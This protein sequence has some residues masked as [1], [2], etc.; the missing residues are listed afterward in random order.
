MPS[1]RFVDRDQSDLGVSQ[2]HIA[3]RSTRSDASTDSRACG[4][5]SVISSEDRRR[6]HQ[7]RVVATSADARTLRY[8]TRPAPPPTLSGSTTTSG[9]S[10]PKPIQ[11]QPTPPPGIGLTCGIGH[12]LRIREP[13]WATQQGAP[14]A[15]PLAAL[16]AAPTLR[17][18]DSYAVHTH[19]R[20]SN[21]KHKYAPDQ[22]FLW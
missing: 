14:P 13:R 12:L 6:L 17:W 20:P 10:L 15:T 21:S 18:G 9:P 22:G 2:A 4:R 16:P 3:V 11:G 1:Q 7:I 5:L 19:T 8:T